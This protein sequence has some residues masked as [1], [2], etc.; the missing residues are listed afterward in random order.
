MELSELTE[1][2]AGLIEQLNLADDLQEF[3]A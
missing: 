1:R 2:N 3:V